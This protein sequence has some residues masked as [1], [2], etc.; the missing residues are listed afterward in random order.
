MMNEARPVSDDRSL[1]EL[2][3]DLGREISTL[4]RQEATLAK[5]ELY[6][7]VVRFGKDAGM[8]AAGVG[9]AYAGL[10][11]IIACIIIAIADAGLAWWASALLVGVVVA[12]LGGLLV[13]Q[14]LQAMKHEELAPRQ[15]I[16][17]VKED[18]QWIRNRAT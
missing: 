2:F 4:V 12:A 7:K 10:L 11:A 17:T 9:V 6:Q 16:E 13:W 5:A 8:V 14:G 3:A 18:A 1:G 15:S